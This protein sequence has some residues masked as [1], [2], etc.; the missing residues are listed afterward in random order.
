MKPNRQGVGREDVFGAT[1]RIS[2]YNAQPASNFFGAG[3]FLRERREL[4]H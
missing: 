2:G 4:A 1:P 3:A